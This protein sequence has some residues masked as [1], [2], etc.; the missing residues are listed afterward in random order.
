MAARG[1]TAKVNIENKIREAFGS[2]FIGVYDKKIYLTADDGGEKVQIAL[3]MTCPKVPVG[4]VENGLDFDNMPDAPTEGT[5]FKPAEITE[6]ETAN[7]RKMLEEL[8][9]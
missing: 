7:I 9:L 8:G 4:Q 1:A 5:E 2:D 6:E 3:S